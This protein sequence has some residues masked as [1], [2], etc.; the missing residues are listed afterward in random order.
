VIDRFQDVP[1]VVAGAREELGETAGEAGDF[2]AAD[3]HFAHAIELF[4]GLGDRWQ[5]AI[6][7]R[8][9]ASFQIHVDRDRAARL[10]VEAIAAER[11]VGADSDLLV[12]VLGAAYLLAWAGRMTEAATLRG[13][14][15]S[16]Q[17]GIRAFW[18]SLAGPGGGSLDSALMSTG[19]STQRERGRRLGIRDAADAAVSWLLQAYAI[20]SDSAQLNSHPDNSSQSV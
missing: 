19:L 17:P 10:I 4:D 8:N 14:V 11:E 1:H 15:P 20:T 13:V 12:A 3:A 9:R 2:E 5:V 18:F 16:V 7:R 6:A